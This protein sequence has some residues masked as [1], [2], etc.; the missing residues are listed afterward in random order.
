MWRWVTRG[1]VFSVAMLLA[2]AAL[3]QQQPTD[4]VGVLELPDPAQTQSGV[5]VIKGWAYDI[6][7]VSKIELYVDDRFQY[8]VNFGQPR[9]DVAEAFPNYPGIHD[10]S[11][12]FLGGFLASRFT[13]G[14][15]T[16]EM[17]VYTGSGKVIALGR[18]TITID[19]TI[20]QAP[21]GFLDIPDGKGVYNASGSFPV[22]GWAIDADGVS[23]VDVLVDSAELQAAMY[24]D[25]RPDV[26][27][28]FP[29]FPASNFS[30]FVAN[31]DTTRLQDGIHVLDVTA[32]DTK[33]MK[34]LIGRRQIQV[35]NA[36]NIDKPFGYL[37]DPKPNTVLYGTQC[38]TIP[39]IF[40]PAFNPQS[41]ITAIRGWALDTGTRTEIGRV[42]Y[43]ELLI[44]GVRWNSTDNCGFN[45]VFGAYA[46]CYGM[47]RYD[48][49]RFYPTYPDSP[50]SGYMFTLDVGAMLAL[51]VPPGRHI[52]KVRVGDN[53][54]TFAELPSRDGIPVTFTCAEE[55]HDFA[56][57]G[58]IDIPT[59]FDYVGGAT[60]FSGW[61]YDEDG[62][63]A[64]IEMVIDGL[65][66]GTAQYGFPRPDVAA[67]YPYLFNSTNSGWRF[68]M[69]TT[70]LSNAR[71]RLVVRVTDVHGHVSEIGSVDF[72]VNNPK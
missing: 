38:A 52:L 30:G 47:P 4:F 39:L 10:S 66:V 53:Q 11:P 20:N 50:M 67:V 34:K 65:S 40:S 64:A 68:V 6:D 49:A 17:K 19:N 45:S 3:A 44:D 48:V 72:Y 29:D 26:S 21:I 69:D 35:F 16:V 5:V 15:H 51:Q 59:T 28:N 1:L 2:A 58:F 23:S 41:H 60:M 55:T 32:T 54:G 63:I 46:N 8:N 18:R 42:D 24:G 57:L 37:D 25:P 9:I 70:Q 61:A 71:H 56:T 14:Q 36:D 62:G 43:V 27:N 22:L 12:G 13:N 31:I 7:Q 33:G